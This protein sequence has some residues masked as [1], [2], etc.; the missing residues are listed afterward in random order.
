MPS[1]QEEIAMVGEARANLM[2]VVPRHIISREMIAPLAA[3]V[4][5]SS[6]IAVAASCGLLPAWAAQGAER[7]LTGLG[8]GQYTDK[9]MCPRTVS[10]TY[11]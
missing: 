10:N 6:L 2:I 3:T 11:D 4:L 5:W 7:L 8:S 1:L 9:P